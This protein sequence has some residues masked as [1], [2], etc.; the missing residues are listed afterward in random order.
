MF[1]EVEPWTLELSGKRKAFLIR[2]PKN[3]DINDLH[4]C[5]LPR[6][7]FQTSVTKAVNDNAYL[8]S[9][10]S[11]TNEIY[12]SFRPIIQ[13]NITGKPTVPDNIHFEGCL[14]VSRNFDTLRNQT[15]FEKTL[16]V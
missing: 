11:S 4:E 12:S 6:K 10:E 15:D 2:M 3:I 7:L 14:N 9:F 5:R 16:V 13:S 8:F 1:E